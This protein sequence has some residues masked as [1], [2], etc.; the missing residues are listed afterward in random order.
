M[1]MMAGRVLLVCALCVLWCGA[2]GVYAR[3]IENNAE[4]VCMVP[5]RFGKKTSYLS[6]GCHKTTPKLSL[7]PALPIP[8]IQAED[9]EEDAG[10]DITLG[11]GGGG[12]SGV[13]S[14]GQG[15]TGSSQA[16]S[17][18]GAGPLPPAGASG[19]GGNPSG[20]VA[21]GG[22]SS[23]DRG[24]DTEASA[25]ISPTSQSESEKKVLQ[26]D[27]AKDQSH[28][29]PNGRAQDTPVV[30]T[31][32]Q[33]SDITRVQDVGDT[34]TLVFKQE[35]PSEEPE[36]KVGDSHTLQTVN[37][38]EDPNKELQ[39]K[40]LP[41]LSN[42][43]L[44]E[45]KT[46]HPKKN[47]EKEKTGR[48]N[49]SASTDSSSKKEG[50]NEDP[51]STSDTAESVSTGSQEQA[52]TTSSNEGSSP[53]Q[54]ET[55]TEKTTVENSQPSDTAQTKKS[56]SVNKE[57]VGDSDGSTAASHTTSPLLLL[58]LVACAAAVVAA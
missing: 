41:E 11:G 52:A 35:R 46:D 9:T 12:G 51:A 22:D 43:P 19:G 47:P 34:S 53:L 14:A 36:K 48:Q 16:G 28:Q 13:N 18:P 4:G 54:K 27:E 55:S 2:G 45:P 32:S 39:E 6:S 3:D 20:P 57:K 1:A 37:S 56:Q 49:T 25:S 8:A 44:P 7:R 24:V 15:V 23:P 33:G 38:P 31:Q 50:N 17:V 26:E 5:G 58:L 10:S 40:A 30:E 29:L 21:P 42:A